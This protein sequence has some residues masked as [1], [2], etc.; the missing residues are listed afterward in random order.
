[1]QK[2]WK[3]LNDCSIN[4][5]LKQSVAW[6]DK[7]NKDMIYCSDGTSLKYFDITDKTWGFANSHLKDPFCFRKLPDFG[8]LFVFV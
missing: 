8:E 6:M 3:S 4:V 5:P 1:M 2:R 7:D